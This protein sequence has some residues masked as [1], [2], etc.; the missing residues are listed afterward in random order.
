MTCEARHTR[1]N[2]GKD[3]PRELG[4]AGLAKDKVVFSGGVSHESHLYYDQPD[5]VGLL[6]RKPPATERN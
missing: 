5:S 4:Y 3:K 6:I 1:E 2:V